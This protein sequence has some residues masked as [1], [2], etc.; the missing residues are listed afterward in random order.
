MH[1]SKCV[2]F[3]KWWTVNPFSTSCVNFTSTF[4]YIVVLK[5]KS[6]KIGWC[7]KLKLNVLLMDD[8]F[9]YSGALFDCVVLA[10]L[11]PGNVSVLLVRCEIPLIGIFQNPHH[12]PSALEAALKKHNTKAIV[13]RKSTQ[14]YPDIRFWWS[15]LA[16]C[17][18]AIILL[19]SSTLSIF[20]LNFFVNFLPQIWVTHHL[21]SSGGVWTPNVA[22]RSH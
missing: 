1:F 4:L 12:L 17:E 5:V 20:F 6:R 21:I 3:H 9:Y 15:C 8:E 14:D 18:Y 11:W 22:I 2:S 16:R 19:Q 7:L 10:C 13:K